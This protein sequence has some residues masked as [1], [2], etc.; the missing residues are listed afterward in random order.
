MYIYIFKHIKILYFI[1]NSDSEVAKE[2]CSV[3]GS[4]K[5]KRATRFP[6]TAAALYNLLCNALCAYAEK[7]SHK[8]SML[9]FLLSLSL[10]EAETP[11]SVWV[12]ASPVEFVTC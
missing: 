8:E 6:V 10:F 2:A 5:A 3:I 12:S 9:T 1:N 7:I 4:P 11:A